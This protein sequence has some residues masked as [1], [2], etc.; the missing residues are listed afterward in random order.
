[1][2]RK[3]LLA[4][5]LL[6]LVSCYP[7]YYATTPF[8]AYVNSQGKV[9]FIVNDFYIASCLLTGSRYNTNL[10][11]VFYNCVITLFYLNTLQEMA[12][13]EFSGLVAD[14]TS[15][16]NHLDDVA[17]VLAQVP[18]DSSN[19]T[20]TFS[21]QLNG[22]LEIQD[23]GACIATGPNEQMC[24]EAGHKILSIVLPASA[25]Q[26]MSN[27][28][29]TAAFQLEMQRS[30]QQETT[31]KAL[32]AFRGTDGN[33]TYYVPFLPAAASFENVPPITIPT[34]SS[35]QEVAPKFDESPASADYVNIV[36][37]SNFSIDHSIS[38]SWYDPQYDGQGWNIQL[39]S[40][41]KAII[42]WFSYKPYGNHQGWFYAVGDVSGNKIVFNQ[43]RETLDGVFGP[44][45]NPDDV[46]Y[47]SWGSMTFVFDDCNSGYM[48]YGGNPGYETGEM[49]IQR[50]TSLSGH[51]CTAP[52]Q[53]FT[54]K[55]ISSNMN[56]PYYDPSHNGEGWLLEILDEQTAVVYWFTYDPYGNQ[57]W[58]VAVGSIQ[59][60]TIQFDTVYRP[61]GA[62]FGADAFDPAD[63]Q[64]NVAGSM[65]FQFSS[66]STGTMSYD[67]TAAGFGQGSLAL[68]KIVNMDGDD[69]PLN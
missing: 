33:K 43:V 28:V 20:G 4:L 62:T 34:A 27:T 29:R 65:Q 50:I 41:E 19:A 56:G 15:Y 35:A 16:K 57:A 45:F 31:V 9:T 69:C 40:P 14:L 48:L 51:T 54:D 13:R 3:T 18:E 17:V 59:G 22:T 61:E 64:R 30:S 39:I 55:A 23:H 24:A 44:Q 25:A 60:D 12:N 37:S 49:H 47:Y 32:F 53:V 58:F 36:S 8:L 10:S 7:M 21:G 63:V 11:E 2:L 68:Q 66:C 52:K 42:Y 6:G 5:S 26:S 38:G 46:R 67:F 1:M